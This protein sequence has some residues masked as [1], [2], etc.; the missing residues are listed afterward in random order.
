MYAKLIDGI[1]HRAPKRLEI[2][3]AIIYN[4]PAEILE[5]QGYKAVQL[6]EQ[7]ATAPE[8]QHW[9][10]DWDEQADAIVQHWYLVNDPD[11]IDPE[12]ALSIILGGAI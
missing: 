6:V 2:G 4:P 7:P 9:E 12:E 3:D 5:N 10:S 1:L 8:G 11:D